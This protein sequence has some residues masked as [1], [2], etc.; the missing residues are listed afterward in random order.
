MEPM[1]GPCVYRQQYFLGLFPYWQR[2]EYVDDLDEAERLIQR[3]TL[4]DKN[5][6]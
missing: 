3:L 5:N 4:L 2:V 6:L 1:V